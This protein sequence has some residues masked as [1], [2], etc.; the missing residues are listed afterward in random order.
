M[1][2]IDLLVDGLDDK[3]RSGRP[4]GIEVRQRLAPAYGQIVMPPVYE[5]SDQ[6]PGELEIHPRTLDGEVRQ[7]TELD[8]VGSS[9]N[10]LEEA[11]L[12]E[13]RAG[14]Y[15]LPLAETA[16]EASGQTFIITSLDA[17]HRVFDAWIRYSKVAGEGVYFEDS[18]QGRELS[19]APPHALDPILETSAHDLLFGTWDSHRTGPSGQVRVARSFTSTV[20]GLDPRPV[21]TR[22]ARRDPL[23]LG[24]AKDIKLAKGEKKLSEQGLSSVPPQVRRPGVSLDEALFVGFLS[25]ASL[26][27]LRFKR[28]DATAA[29]VLL[30]S[31]AL[32]ALALRVEQ[33]WSLRS[34]CELIPTAELEL[35]VLRTGAGKRESL[36]LD[37]DATASMLDEALQRA[38]LTDRSVQLVGSEKLT[39]LVEKAISTSGHDG[40]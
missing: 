11:L 1:N 14:R 13:R 19:L 24:D 26:R 20:L 5:R 16:I 32:H 40:A 7:V 10:R 38:G 23:N 22:A 6:N 36:V 30:A 12:E 39:A 31:L 18:E 9:A 4:A 27:R 35:A 2:T 25:F 3:R 21:L 34:E 29:R 28:Y 37:A 8:S 17:P 15:A 33:G